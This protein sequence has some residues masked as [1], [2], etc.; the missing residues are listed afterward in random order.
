MVQTA[1]SLAEK[2]AMHVL[3]AAIAYDTVYATLWGRTELHFAVLT[4]RMRLAEL[5]AENAA[6]HGAEGKASVIYFKQTLLPSSPSASI[7][8]SSSAPPPAASRPPPPPASSPAAG[9]AGAASGGNAPVPNYDIDAVHQVDVENRL[10]VASFR[11]LLPGKEGLG[12]ELI[13]FDAEFKVI[14]V[15]TIRHHKQRFGH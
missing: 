6:M 11:S 1:V 15:E 13:K 7:P 5:L 14:G 4:Y 10:V 9:A 3:H 8:S 12:T 2:A